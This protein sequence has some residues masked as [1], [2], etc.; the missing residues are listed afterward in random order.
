MRSSVESRLVRSAARVCGW[1]ALTVG[2]VTLLDLGAWEY[3]IDGSTPGDR[4]NMIV[5][6]GPHLLAT[7]EGGKCRLAGQRTH[8]ARDFDEGPYVLGDRETLLLVRTA[9]ALVPPVVRYAAIREVAFLSV[10]TACAWTSSAAFIDATGLRK[11][12]VVCLGPEASVLLVLHE[13]AH[14]FCRPMPTEDSQAITAQGEEGFREYM[15]AAGA[16]DLIERFE[17]KAEAVADGLALS[18]WYSQPEVERLPA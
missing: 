7:T 12:T 11:T 16:G 3:A 9:L 1:P 5:A 17:R 13:I 6:L 8:A 2:A 18:W 4:V 10:G 14:A 15:V